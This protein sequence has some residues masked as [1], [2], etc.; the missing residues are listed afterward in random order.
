MPGGLGAGASARSGVR[1]E[2]FPGVSIFPV[3]A[4]PRGA[5]GGFGGGS[6]AGVAVVVGTSVSE[7]LLISS[8]IIFGKVADMLSSGADEERGA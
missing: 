3:V 4:D 6:G 8:T 7:G 5:S 2:G 1:T